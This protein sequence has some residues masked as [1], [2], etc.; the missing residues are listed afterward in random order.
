MRKFLCLL[1]CVFCVSFYS[2]C[3][4]SELRLNEYDICITLNED[5][6]LDGELTLNYFNNTKGEVDVLEFMLYPNAFSKGSKIK[7]IYSEYVDKAFESG[8]SYGGIDVIN[9]NTDSTALNYEVINEDSHFL[10]V[11]LDK[12]LKKGDSAEINVEF[13][14]TLP[15]VKHRFGYTQNTVNLTGFYPILCPLE[16]GEYYKS[17]YCASGDPFY[18]EVANYKVDFKVPSNY[19]IASSMSPTGVLVEGQN[20]N[21]YYE[22][23][24]VREVAFILS[25]NFN[26]VKN[27]I[28]GVDVFY[29][30]YQDKNAENSLETAVKAI[31]FFSSKIAKYP[32]NEYVFCEADFIYGGMEYPCLTMID[33]SLSDFERDY[34][35]VHETAHQWWYGLVGVNQNEN[36]FIDEGLTEYST[37]LFFDNYKEYNKS[38]LELLTAVYN[39]YFELRKSLSKQQSVTPKMNKNLREFTSDIDYVSIAYYRSQLMF[40][41]LS[42]FMG[43]NRFNSFLKSLCKEYAYKNLTLNNFLL[44][45]EKYKKGAKGFLLD[46]INGKSV[47]K[48]PKNY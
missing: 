28:N 23:N 33:S 32:Y 21:Y 43:E 31:A 9:V 1:L 24:S 29:Y 46:Y 37:T 17:V 8:I 6:T 11:Y 47:V 19:V 13:F 30:Y 34:T 5:M 12:A 7:P 42:N 40:Y 45:A 20:T 3:K 15:N 44:C 2:G 36:A 18:S 41:E 26:V 14:I 48:E 38:K 4:K 35:I 39:A 10:K 27:S 25:K 16:N 22:R